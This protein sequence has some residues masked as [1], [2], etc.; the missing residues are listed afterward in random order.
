LQFVVH[1][2][3]LSVTVRTPSNDWMVENNELKLTLKRSWPTLRHHP[4][5]Q[6]VLRR[7]LCQY[8][9]WHPIS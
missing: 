4:G 7:K 3:T 8:G 1:L 9:L 2:T 6:L 5:S